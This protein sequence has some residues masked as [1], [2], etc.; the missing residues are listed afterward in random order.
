[1]EL[2]Q[3]MNGW[4]NKLTLLLFDIFVEMQEAEY[5]C[6][7]YHRRHKESVRHTQRLQENI[8][9]EVGREQQFCQQCSRLEILCFYLFQ[10]K[11][12]VIDTQRPLT[13]D[14]NCKHRVNSSVISSDKDMRTNSN[15]ADL[16]YLSIECSLPDVSAQQTFFS[17][18]S[19]SGS[20]SHKIF[21]DGS[22][23]QVVDSDRALSLLSSGSSIN[24]EIGLNHHMVQFGGSMHHSQQPL[25]HHSLQHFSSTGQ[26]LFQQD[27]ES[28]PVVSA[29]ESQIRNLSN[30]P[31]QEMFPDG[32]DGAVQ[33]VIHNRDYIY[34]SHFIRET[35]VFRLQHK[36]SLLISVHEED[37]SKLRLF[38]VCMSDKGLG[39]A[40]P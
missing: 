38:L 15:Q 23:H 1:M 6:R 13:M 10:S 17:P 22:S 5:Q 26:Y 29:A 31:F 27:I 11:T 37:F 25:A 30:L 7:E 14:F 19:A 2:C 40:F 3:T 4:E 24:R 28:K 9:I 34:K 8:T 18:S 21:S 33:L 16:N 36:H 12:S 35:E 39:F 20:S 32:P